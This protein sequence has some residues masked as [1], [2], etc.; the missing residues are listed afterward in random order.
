LPDNFGVANIN[1][2]IAKIVLKEG[3]NKEFIKRI[4][5]SNIC[6]LQTQ[7]FLTTSAQP[8]INFEQIKSIK[9]PYP[10]QETQNK[11]A[12]EV[13]RRMSEAERLKNEASKIIEESKKKVEEMILG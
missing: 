13:K 8:N 7:R 11:I 5:N 12:E 3:V 6:K 9:I 1:Q 10:I 4:L 2:A